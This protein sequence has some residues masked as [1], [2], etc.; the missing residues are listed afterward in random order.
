LNIA[1]LDSEINNFFAEGCPLI[2]LCCC[3]SPCTWRRLTILEIMGK[4]S[5]GLAFSGLQVCHASA[6]RDCEQ[7]QSAKNPDLIGECSEEG[8]PRTNCDMIANEKGLARSFCSLTLIFSVKI[9]GR[10]KYSVY[11]LEG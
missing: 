7:A 9:K 8:A 3:V 2:R 6:S 10:I 4:E 1:Q 5:I 11:K